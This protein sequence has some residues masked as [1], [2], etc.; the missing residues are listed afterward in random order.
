MIH[1]LLIFFVLCSTAVSVFF[2]M[3]QLFFLVQCEWLGIAQE[4]R[5]KHSSPRVDVD[6]APYAPGNDL[7]YVTELEDA[8]D[9]IKL[10]K[11]DDNLEFFFTET[12]P[13]LDSDGTSGQCT[14]TCLDDT[15]SAQ[16]IAD[17]ITCQFEKR[18]SFGTKIEFAHSA[19]QRERLGLDESEALQG[20]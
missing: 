11:S 17:I 9:P 1:P 4:S 16:P 7:L 8:H 20:L 12:L 14:K 2:L 3:F 13:M 10:L 5:K 19:V 15:Y 18:H 6:E